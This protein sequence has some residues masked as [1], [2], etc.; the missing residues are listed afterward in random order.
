MTSHL[1]FIVAVRDASETLTL[2]RYVSLAGSTTVPVIK[3]DVREIESPV[4]RFDAS[5]VSLSP[6]GSHANIARV[7][8][9][10]SFYS[11][12]PGFITAGAVGEFGTSMNRSNR[13]FVILRIPG[14]MYPGLLSAQLQDMVPLEKTFEPAEVS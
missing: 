11:W 2:V 9:S 13:F 6:W 5:Y 7:I 14:L 3:P 8:A 12:F 1:K 4:G 10:P